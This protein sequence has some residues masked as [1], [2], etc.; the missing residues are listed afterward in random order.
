MKKFFYVCLII[1]ILLSMASCD[2][3]TSSR[4]STPVKPVQTEVKKEAGPDFQ[5]IYK[6]YCDSRYASVGSDGSYLSIDTNPKD[7]PSYNNYPGAQ[8]AVIAVNNALGLPES[9]LKDMSE[10]SALMGKQTESFPSLGITVSWSYHP[11]YGLEIVYKK[12]N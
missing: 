1:L 3:Q 12:S 5:A 4:P 8:K 6:Q 11:D 7:S 9:L 2:M 10:T